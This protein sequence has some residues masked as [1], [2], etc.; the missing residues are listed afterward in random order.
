M[1]QLLMRALAVNISDALWKMPNQLLATVTYKGS[2][3]S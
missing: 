3:N 2:S 1:P